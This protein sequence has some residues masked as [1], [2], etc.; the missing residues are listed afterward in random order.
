M[1]SRVAWSDF[2][3]AGAGRQDSGWRCLG[4]WQRVGI[5]LAARDNSGR[6]VVLTP[7]LSDWFRCWSRFR[8]THAPRIA[9]GL[10]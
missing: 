6:A 1:P 2:L 8:A 5:G 7:E 10:G 9:D 4:W 3:R